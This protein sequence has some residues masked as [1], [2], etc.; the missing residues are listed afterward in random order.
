MT[1]T[2]SQI[3]TLVYRTCLLLDAEKFDDYLALCSTDFH[4]QIKADSPEL[5]KEMVWLDLNREELANLLENVPNH[6]R[7]PGK[8]ARQ[9]TVYS[10][11]RNADDSQAEVTTSLIVIYTDLEG[12]SRIFAAGMYIDTVA[13]TGATPT[14][15]T[16]TVQLDTRDLGPGSHIPL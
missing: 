7:L 16:R 10:I 8:F 11:A 3:S 14:L 2:D 4:Y 5:G 9:A 13:L 6:I 15:T 1:A 12:I